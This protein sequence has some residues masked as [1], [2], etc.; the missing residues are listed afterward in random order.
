MTR[1][2]QNQ[3][4]SDLTNLLNGYTTI[5]VDF[6]EFL[7]DGYYMISDFTDDIYETSSL[8]EW[9]GLCSVDQSLISI[10]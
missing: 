3:A 9:L 5:E 10:W 4:A 2:Q 8:D 7:E 6:N 1:Q